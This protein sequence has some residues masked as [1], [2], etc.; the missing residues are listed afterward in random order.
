MDDTDKDGIA[1]YLDQE[2]N[3]PAGVTVD[4][5]GKYIDLNR[6]G[7]PD[8]LEKKVSNKNNAEVIVSKEDAI[9]NLV[10]KG[11]VN[12]FYDVNEDEPNSGSTNSV[13]Y[14]VQFLR[15]YP[16]AKIKLLGYADKRGN[17]VKNVNL[18]QRRAQNLSNLIISSG[19]S[20]DRIEVVG[21]GID[22]SY[23]DETKSGLN[24]ARRV[25]ITIN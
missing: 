6:N 21:Q 13:F 20:K 3:T 7:V 4:S 22:N 1:D 23:N 10:D 17:E 24:L 25:S 11:Y 16:D 19:I 14:L 9:K 2:N 18:S 12:I 5:R 15:Q 8:E